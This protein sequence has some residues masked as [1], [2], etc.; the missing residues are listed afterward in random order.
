MGE[1]TSV[2]NGIPIT[3]GCGYVTMDSRS[4][5]VTAI[6]AIAICIIGS[7]MLWGQTDDHD[8]GTVVE[9]TVVRYD[10]FGAA[11]LSVDMQTMDSLKAPYGSDLSVEINGH[12]YTAIFVKNY[13][14]A[15]A[16][17]V[18]VN[19][20][21]SEEHYTLGVFN[22]RF[23]E[24]QVIPIGDTVK[25]SVNGMNSYYPRIPNY[26]K[27]YSNDRDDY[28]SD[29]AF[30]NCRMLAGGDLA[31]GRVYRCSTPWGEHGRG[32]ICDE[33]L[34]EAGV[35]YLIGMDKSEK[36]VAE[37]VARTGD[38]YSSQ[39]F[40]D[41]RVSVRFLSPA[42]HSNPEEIRWVIDRILESDGSIGIF[43]KLG[44][45]RTG[46]Y[47]TI[48]QGVAG[49]TLE[50]ATDDFMLSITNYYGLEKGTDEYNAVYEMLLFRQL[51][52]FQHPEM[53]DHV[54]DI[55]WS[56]VE[57]KDFDLQEVII[58]FLNGYVGIPMDKIDA[59]RVRLTE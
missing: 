35:D 30:A 44:K 59:L 18:Y 26:L 20:D 41:G 45:D 51:Y 49:A 39:L 32:A 23:T 7:Y 56:K 58:S 24:D 47:C 1:D 46:M 2:R 6:F 34:K 55:D 54:L 4:K 42:V 19:F 48:L 15:P 31:E 37:M 10:E 8:D 43:C 57:L 16:F 12:E 27:G 17:S 40:L 36:A 38:L 21:S 25:L 5:V 28:P 11:V 50:E 33:F 22:S 52:L 14:G 3:Y 13:A 29:Q 9:C 53:I